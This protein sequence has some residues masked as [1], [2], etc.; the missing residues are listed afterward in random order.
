VLWLMGAAGRYWWV[1]AWGT[2]MAFAM[3]TLWA[4]PR[5]IAPLFN[6]FTPLADQTLRERIEA[7]LRRAGF[8]SR[9]IFVMDGSRR[10]G[11]G[12]AYFTG[13]GREKRIV[14]FDTLLETLSPTEVEAVLAHELGHFRRRHVQKGLAWLGGVSLG[15]F[16]LLGW[17]AQQPWF[18]DG[19]GLTHPSAH[20]ALALFLLSVPLLGFFLQPIV[21]RMS[22]AHEY[23][24]DDYAA[25]QV[26]PEA[27]ISALVKLSKEN[28][29]TLTPDP[30]YSAFYDTHPPAPLRIAHLLQKNPVSTGEVY[31]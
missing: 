19:L 27:L 13:L 6:R 24:A 10:S 22:R 17:I 11:H 21:A 14:F 29:S 31:A 5:V 2:W 28:A 9:G 4:F 25:G 26:S 18:Y 3:L 15:A 20:G 12:N 7:L 23:Q 16:G 8:A 30:L 1:Y